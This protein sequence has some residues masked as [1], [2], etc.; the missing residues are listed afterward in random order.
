M[1]TTDRGSVVVSGRSDSTLNR[2]GVRLGSADIYAVVDGLPQIRDSPVIGAELGDGAYWLVL[3]VVPADGV[4][5]TEELIR[6]VTAEIRGRASPRH[7]PDD[8]VAVPVIP[9]TRTGKRLEVP[10]KRLI[11][12]HPLDQVA[13]RDAVDDFAALAQ[14]TAFAGGPAS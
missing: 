5:L 7:V 9:H 3:F 10:G 6:H 4:P 2:H 13:G 8:V 12:G 14:F 11:Q 1:L